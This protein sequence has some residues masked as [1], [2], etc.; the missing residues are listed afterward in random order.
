MSNFF[1]N[2]NLTRRRTVET[3]HIRI[4]GGKAR[5]NK[6]VGNLFLVE[7]NE[8]LIMIKI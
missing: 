1:H 4:L 8:F 2:Y 6:D 7:M 3:A 5:K